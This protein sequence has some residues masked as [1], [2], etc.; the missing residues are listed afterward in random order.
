[1]ID[2]TVH[3]NVWYPMHDGAQ[4]GPVRRQKPAKEGILGNVF[5]MMKRGVCNCKFII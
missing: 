1:M 3:M 5:E 4:T 2:K